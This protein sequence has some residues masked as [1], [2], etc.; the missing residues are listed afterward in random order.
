M[1][2]TTQ[3]FKTCPS[4]HKANVDIEIL[5]NHEKKNKSNA[6]IESSFETWKESRIVRTWETVEKE[7][8]M[9]ERTW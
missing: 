2:P 6:R 1:A 9:H 7:I 4:S 5:P 8:V 3:G